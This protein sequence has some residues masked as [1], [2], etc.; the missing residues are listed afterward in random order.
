[1]RFHRFAWDTVATVC[2]VTTDRDIR[3]LRKNGGVRGVADKAALV[4]GGA[5][6]LLALGRT[7]LVAVAWLLAGVVAAGLRGAFERPASTLVP[8]LTVV[9]LAFLEP[10]SVAAV[11]LGV[12]DLTRA[13]AQGRRWA[14]VGAVGVAGAIGAWSRLPGALWLG[15][16]LCGFAILL[17]AGTVREERVRALL[18]QV[19]D[20]LSGKLRALQVA[21]AELAEAGEDRARNVVLAERTRIARDIHDGVGH[22]LTRLLYRTKA[23]ELTQPQA[24]AELR[25]LGAGL[26]AS[27]DAVRRSVHALSDSGEELGAALHTLAMG[28]GLEVSVDCPLLEEPPARVTRCLVAVVKEALTNAARHGNATSAA[29]RIAD[30]PAFWQ[31]TVDNDGAALAEDWSGAAAE[32]LGL[33]S[34]GDRVEALG[35]TLRF[36][37]APTFRVFA[38]IPKERT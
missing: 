12:Y 6:V 2:A 14:A 7:D 17:A 24:A 31:I 4:L 38:T 8:T 28:C 21:H 33:R 22:D 23:L 20:D 18:H 3:H 37:P 29:V 13:T 19:R 35:G 27:L 11:P 25:E 30:Y 34:M 36:D 16:V 32:G 1:M 10:V 15:F 9:G 26:T 5:A